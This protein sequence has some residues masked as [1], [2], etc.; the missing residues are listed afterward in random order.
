MTLKLT[1]CLGETVALQDSTGL[2]SLADVL[3]LE[4]TSACEHESDADQGLEK[5]RRRAL[6]GDRRECSLHGVDGE[7]EQVEAGLHLPSHEAQE[8][9]EA[10]GSEGDGA[11]KTCNGARVTCS[12]WES[13]F[14]R[15]PYYA[16]LMD[17]WST[18]MS[19]C[20]AINS[21]PKR[22]ERRCKEFMLNEAE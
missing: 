19:C 13:R 21:Q 12:K 10:E 2:G 6:S 16:S 22:I 18:T 11:Q 1:G 3:A 14:S 20:F 8:E 15:G 7:D 4:I 9:V 5:A 17:A